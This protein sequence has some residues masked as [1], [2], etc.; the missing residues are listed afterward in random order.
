VTTK[1]KSTSA[2]TIE[3]DAL[4]FDQRGDAGPTLVM[5]V[6]SVKKIL[7]FSEVGA[8]SPST[9][10]PQRE[11]KEARVEAIAKF[12]KVDK[13]NTIPTAIILA[14]EKGK[15][16]FSGASTVGTLRV[17]VGKTAAATIVDGQHRLF[18]IQKADPNIEV[19]VV[20]D[21]PAFLDSFR[22]RDKW[23][24]AMVKLPPRGAEV[25]SI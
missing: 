10:G 14:F 3:F 8:L 12:I 7:S 15:A 4:S 6:A 19:P 21:G 25:Q 1:K 24:P 9:Q 2:L 22:G 11:Q 13:G 5:F 20:R 17:K 23:I 18:G 16:S